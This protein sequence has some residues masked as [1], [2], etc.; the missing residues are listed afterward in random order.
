MRYKVDKS[1]IKFSQQFNDA[2]YACY[3]VGGAVRNLYAGLPVS[4]YDFA[5]DARPDDVQRLFKRV[6]PTGIKHGTVTVLYA[7]H[8][9]E[10]TT[11]REDGEY[12]DSRRPDNVQFT[13]SIFEDLK[14]RDF[15]INSMAYDLV[16]GVLLDPHEGKAD[17]ERKLIRAIGV[18]SERFQEDALRIMRACRFAAQLDFIIDDDTLAGMTEKAENLRAVSAERIRDE[19]EKILKAEKPSTAF[20]VMEKTG[21][22]K[23]ILPELA[24]CRGV[25]QKG[26]HDFDVLDHMLYSCDGAPPENAEVRLAALLHDIGKPS[27]I[28]W[29]ELGIPTFHSHELLSVSISRDIIQRFKFPKAF[30]KHVL[31]L[32]EQH[33]F[34][35]QNEWTDSAVRRFIARV[36]V[37]NIK[38]LFV[39]RRADQ[40]GMR[41]SKILPLNLIEFQKR[42]EAILEAENAFRISD[43]KINGN[44]L[45]KDGGIPRG[46]ALGKVLEFL[47]ESV[48]EDPELNNEEKLLEIGIKFYSER[49]KQNDRSTQ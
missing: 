22:L 40:F 46:P 24:S 29:D 19:L 20:R 28:N 45:Q 8:N 3:L 31:L 10:V 9:L 4:D 47:L 12:T 42:I 44:T 7:G 16:T 23:V 17:L 35:Y 30:E 34:H 11:F 37:E 6:I 43:L 27:V 25:D 33:M 15:T 14:R 5:T 13:P 38:N 48:L 1:L 49:L 21:I 2:G 26:Y 36:G 41:G 39:L 18:P 32:I